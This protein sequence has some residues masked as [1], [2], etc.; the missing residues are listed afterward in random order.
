[1]D[2]ARGIGEHTLN[3][4]PTCDVIGFSIDTLEH[5]SAKT[6]RA[7]NRGELQEAKGGQIIDFPSPEG[8]ARKEEA[9]LSRG[10]SRHFP[11][12]KEGYLKISLSR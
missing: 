4:S 12:A 2:V 3:Q 11:S 1:M 5:W 10:T 6:A 8:L 9:A 7:L